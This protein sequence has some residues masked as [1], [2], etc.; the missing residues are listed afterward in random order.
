MQGL[1]GGEVKYEEI[2]RLVSDALRGE[3]GPGSDLFNMAFERLSIADVILDKDEPLF[4]AQVGGDLSDDL[5][6]CAYKMDRMIPD[7]EKVKSGRFNEEGR[8]VFYF[9]KEEITALKE[10][11]PWCGAEEQVLEILKGQG[12]EAEDVSRQNVGYDIECKTPDGEPVFVEVKL[13]GSCDKPFTMTSNEEAVARQKGEQYVIA[14]VCQS[15]E[16]LEVA[17]IRDPVQQLEMTRQCR[18]WAWECSDYPYEPLRFP[19]E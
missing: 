7:P 9:A 10:V 13:V 18:Q 14:I 1:G 5:S 19:M 8:S 11:R 16:F 2:Y 12:W 17:F 3:I 4:R 6:V 15:R